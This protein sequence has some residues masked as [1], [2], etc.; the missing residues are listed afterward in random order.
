[1]ASSPRVQVTV[2]RELAEALDSVNPN[3]ASRSRLIRDLAIKGSEVA[4]DDEARRRRAAD[5]LIGIS[6]GE[7]DY[8]FDGL[9]EMHEQREAGYD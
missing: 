7:I 2:D 3:P 1:M 5:Y 8:D 9:R 6:N 4:R